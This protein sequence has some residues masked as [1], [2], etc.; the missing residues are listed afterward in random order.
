MVIF[1]DY[2]E[3]ITV[4]Y[5]RNLISNR[6]YTSTSLNFYTKTQ[7]FHFLTQIFKIFRSKVANFLLSCDKFFAFWHKNLKFYY[8]FNFIII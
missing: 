2:S 3:L 1:F 6:E 5:R 8:K 7:M 4:M